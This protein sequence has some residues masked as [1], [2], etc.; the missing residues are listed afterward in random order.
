MSNLV[1][2]YCVYTSNSNTR[3]INSNQRVEEKLRKIEETRR[4]QEMAEHMEGDAENAASGEFVE[5]LNAN[6]V[7]EIPEVSPD[8]VISE[9]KDEAERIINEAKQKADSI[10]EDAIRQAD[11]LI[12]NKKKQGYE[13]GFAKGQE[14][15]IQIREEVN[16]NALAMEQKLEQE[17]KDKFD[18][19]ESDLIEAIIQ[20]FNK[21]FDIQF[22]DKK[23]IM[24]HLVKNTLKN[25]EVGRVFR[26][27]VS[28]NNYKFMETH[29]YD[30]RQ[31]IGNDVEV[32]IVNDANL[33]AEDCQ[34]ETSFGVF[35]CGIDMELNNLVKDIRSL[36]S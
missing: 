7:E 24:L 10:M 23:E 8:E 19:M 16:A 35:D 3:I 21:V 28:D 34:I 14:E 1:K 15:L 20:V 32:E 18:T 25:V 22:D 33:G 13:D 30:I 26:I 9:A 11:E 5:G 36:C 17:Y 31:R 29:L 2:Q 4:R 27:H 12:E 6:Y